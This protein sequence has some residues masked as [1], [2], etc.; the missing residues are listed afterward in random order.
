MMDKLD[1]TAGS[2]ETQVSNKGRTSTRRVLC[3]SLVAVMG[4]LIAT[5]ELGYWVGRSKSN[6]E[7]ARRVDAFMATHCNARFL[8]AG[9]RQPLPTSDPIELRLRAGDREFAYR[10]DTEQICDELLPAGDRQALP[11]QTKDDQLNLI[12]PAEAVVIAGAGLFPKVR[13][14]IEWLEKV[15][16]G[17]IL[18][19]AAAVGVVGASALWGYSLGFKAE[20]NFSSKM[21]Q[22]RLHDRVVWRGLERDYRSRQTSPPPTRAAPSVTP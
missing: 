16:N 17:R 18:G 9:D 3:L 22:E 21:F 11:D 14:P 19:V 13:V 4:F 15:R 1:E 6:W 2:Q 10:T 5:F 8:V 7:S 12:H 20:P